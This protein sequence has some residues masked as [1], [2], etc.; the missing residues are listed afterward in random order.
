MRGDCRAALTGYT[1]LGQVTAGRHSEMAISYSMKVLAVYLGTLLLAG[2]KRGGP[3]L[4]FSLI[5]PLLLSLFATCI[6][7]IF[8]HFALSSIPT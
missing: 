2:S 4:P 8:V 1:G 7:S 6:H 3:T 5:W